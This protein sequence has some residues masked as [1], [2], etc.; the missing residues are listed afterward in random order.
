MDSGRRENVSLEDAMR[1]G[2]K[3]G[4]ETFE[5]QQALKAVKE[6]RVSER[7]YAEERRVLRVNRVWSAGAMLVAF[8]AVAMGLYLFWGGNVGGGFGCT[9]IALLFSFL[10]GFGSA[11]G[12][13]IGDKHYYAAAYDWAEKKH[14]RKGANA[15]GGE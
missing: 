15:V 7:A 6:G 4:F 9:T 1:R 5:R 8:V 3:E 13:A 2:V 10:H 14:R 11:V 12:K